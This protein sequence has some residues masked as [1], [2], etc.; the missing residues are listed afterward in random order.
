ML[1]LHDIPCS[2]GPNMLYDAGDIKTHVL[3]GYYNYVAGHVLFNYNY[4]LV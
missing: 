3:F 4:A 1:I 2:E